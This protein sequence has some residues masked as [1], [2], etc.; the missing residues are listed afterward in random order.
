MDLVINVISGP[1]KGQTFP[2]PPGSHV[3]GRGQKAAVKLSPEDVSWEHAVLTREGDDYFIENLSAL[4]T[5]VGDT[6][7]AGRVRLRP[8]DKIRLSGDCIVRLEPPGGGGLFS[9]RAFL[10]LL[11]S[12]ML[13]LAVAAVFYSG[14]FE[15]SGSSV[16][17][18][19]N[20][21]R[22]LA[23]W[24][25]KQATKGR[26]PRE[27]VDLFDRVWRLNRPTT[28]KTPPSFGSACRSCCPLPKRTSKHSNWPVET[29]TAS[30]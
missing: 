7:V 22:I 17:D 19:D 26:V 23:P 10:G 28:T 5:W 29:P 20:A 27:A 8:R 13:S 12:V 24:L 16:D 3:I 15:G 6:K 25:E 2:V 21:H 1:E 14:E 11:L 30:S 18:W 9:S 4:G